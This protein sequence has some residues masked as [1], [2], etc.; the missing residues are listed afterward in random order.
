VAVDVEAV[1]MQTILQ[2]FLAKL[3]LTCGEVVAE[4]A[5]AVGVLV[6]TVDLVG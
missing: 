6:E 4:A 2:I 1:T 3:V 5:E